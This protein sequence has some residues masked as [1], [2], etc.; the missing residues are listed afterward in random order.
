MVAESALIDLWLPVTDLF[1]A[2]LAILKRIALVAT[3]NET[4]DW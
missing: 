3:F 1:A 4:P 2:E